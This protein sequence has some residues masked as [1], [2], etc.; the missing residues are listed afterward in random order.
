MVNSWKSFVYVKHVDLGNVRK[1]GGCVEVEDNNHLL[2]ALR[3][4]LGL[5]PPR[6]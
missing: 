4:K 5:L 1:F 3:I 6:I 2:P